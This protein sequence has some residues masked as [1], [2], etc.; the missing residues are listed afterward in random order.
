MVIGGN[1]TVDS[2]STCEVTVASTEDITVVGTG[3]SDVI[4]VV[5]AAGQVG[6]VGGQSMIVET[7]VIKE[8]LVTTFVGITVVVWLI[9]T[10]T[11]VGIGVTTVVG[12]RMVV[13]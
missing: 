9:T 2:C 12:W 6:M 10:V 8:T 13:G 7:S 4:N 5:E 3:T 1:V 11:N